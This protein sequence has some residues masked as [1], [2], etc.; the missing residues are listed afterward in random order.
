LKVGKTTLASEMPKPLLLA[1]EKGYNAI[2]GVYAQDITS[3]SEMRQV[4]REL[5]KPEVQEMFSTICVDTVDIM[6]TYCDKYVCAQ[7]GVNNIGEVPYGQGWN[8]LKKEFEDVFRTIAQLGYAVLFISHSKEATFKR[9][10]G[11]EY[12]MIR[13]SVANTYNAIVENMADLYIYMHPVVN[14]GKTEVRMTLRSL[15]GSV[16][17][18]GRFKYIVPEIPSNY[19]AL[20]KALNDAIDEEAKHK[21]AEFVTDKKETIVSAPDYDY[22][23]LMKEFNTVSAGLMSRDKEYYGPRI[24]SIIGKILGKGKKISESTPDQAELISLIVSEVKEIKPKAE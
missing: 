4:L 15:D 14:D 24:T 13:P 8:L 19:E 12:T 10:D 11:T 17:A 22:D 7:N 3:W 6:A 16:A 23:A 9:Q 1:A 2:A 18:G 5:K 21:G 20:C